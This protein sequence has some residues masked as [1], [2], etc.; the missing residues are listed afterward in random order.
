[1]HILNQQRTADA[2]AKRHYGNLAGDLGTVASYPEFVRELGS[3]FAGVLTALRSGCYCCINVMDLRKKDCFYPLH[4]D[5]ARELVD[6]GFIFDDLV[7][8]NRGA[9]YNNLRPL[10]YP[11]TFRINKVH[12]Y[13]V[14]LRKPPMR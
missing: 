4:A 3:I 14:I 1:W 6:R 5:L 13:V 9:E 7:I 11:Y 12:E 8:W 10:G 2:K